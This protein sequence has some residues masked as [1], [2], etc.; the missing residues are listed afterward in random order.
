MALN[1][2]VLLLIA[3][4]SHVLDWGELGHRTVGYLAQMYFTAEAE[5]LF[6][7]L[8]IPTEA[9]DISDGAVWADNFSVQSRYPWSKPL[10]FIDANDEPPTTCGVNID[11][12]CDWY[13][14][15]IVAAISNFVRYRLLFTP[16]MVL[17]D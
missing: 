16:V 9:F 15:C 2:K 4:T 17:I 7:D 5:H 11:A 12:D 1:T 13:K 3:L 10:H 6:S 8:I 14:R